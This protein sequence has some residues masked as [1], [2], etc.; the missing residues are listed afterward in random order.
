MHI[1][2]F[3]V[4]SAFFLLHNVVLSVRSPVMIHYGW[5][6]CRSRLFDGG[7]RLE[8]NSKNK[9]KSTTPRWKQ[10]YDGSASR[11][12]QRTSPFRLS[13]THLSH[14]N[15]TNGAVAYEIDLEYTTCLCRLPGIS[16]AG[17]F[18]VKRCGDD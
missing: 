4:W 13:E 11:I 1:W 8:R 15:L 17:G 12:S 2:V 6:T 7:P 3:P 10:T 5:L 9:M 14:C 18:I 16:Q